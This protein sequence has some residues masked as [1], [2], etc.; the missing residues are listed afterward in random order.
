MENYKVFF[1]F[2][3]NYKLTFSKF[4]ETSKYFSNLKNFQEIN[5]T[6]APFQT[7]CNFQFVD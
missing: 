7:F 6:F 2:P 5:L 4:F 3:K 1:R